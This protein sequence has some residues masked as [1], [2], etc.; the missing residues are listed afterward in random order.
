MSYNE[1][2]NK[3]VH[4]SKGEKFMSH[5]TKYESNVLVNTDK[6]LLEDALAE[7]GITL[8]SSIKK[9][10]NSLKRVIEGLL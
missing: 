2:P 9:V 1:I 10:K 7:L 3:I 4:K 5:L 8:D 6:Y